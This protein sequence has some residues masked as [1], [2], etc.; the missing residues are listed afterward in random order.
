[1]FKQERKKSIS[2]NNG[3]MLPIIDKIYFSVLLFF[4]LRRSDRASRFINLENYYW[5]SRFLA[6][7]SNTTKKNS[8]GISY[9]IKSLYIK[10][11]SFFSV[12]MYFKMN[13]KTSSASFYK[14]VFLS[15]FVSEMAS[16]AKSNIPLPNVLTTS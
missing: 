10:A 15:L 2:S 9:F 1:M 11:K 14:F 16:K 4:L 8:S 6:T 7:S 3:Q 12:M 5:H 13:A